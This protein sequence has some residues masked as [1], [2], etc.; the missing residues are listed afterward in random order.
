MFRPLHRLITDDPIGSILQE[1]IRSGIAIFAA[2]TNLDASPIGVNAVLAEIFGL[3]NQEPL[4]RLPG[5]EVF[6]LVTFLPAEHLAKVSAALFQSGAGVIGD[7]TGC[8]FRVEGT[9]TFTP[10]SR[11]HPVYGE[12]GK[13]NDVPEVR[14]E[15]VAEE[16]VLNDAIQ[17]LVS[18]H[19]YEE[20]AYDVYPLVLGTSAGMGRV[21]DLPEAVNLGELVRGCSKKL[22]NRA[23]RFTGDSGRMIGRVAL[24]SGSGAKLASKALQS[25]AQALITGDVGYHESMNAAAMGLA[26]IDAGHYHTERPVIARL[27]SLLAEKAEQ[28]GLEIEVN[29]SGLDT[30]PWSEEGDD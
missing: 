23:V 29:A 21:G 13:P 14:L 16:H 28:A 3:E 7:Y 27:A 25:G 12:A 1:A 17:A 20:P 4:E 5:S 8:S 30:S 24:C 26:I 18:A 15:V 11:S 6:K 2:H 19:P 10:G 9:G 22:G